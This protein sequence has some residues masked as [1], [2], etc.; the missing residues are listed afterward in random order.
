MR[1]PPGYDE[2][3]QAAWQGHGWARSEQVRRRVVFAEPS[4]S[5]WM[6]LK[7]HQNDVAELQTGSASYGSD[8]C[9]SGEAVVMG[10]PESRGSALR[11]SLVP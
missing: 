7:R 4:C 8:W 10:V 3:D 1:I 6:N 11:T 5:L 2:M 9:R